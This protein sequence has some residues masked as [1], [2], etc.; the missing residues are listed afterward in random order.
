VESVQLCAA[1]LSCAVVVVF[2]LAVSSKR[3][4][5]EDALDWYMRGCVTAAIV[6]VYQLAN[7]ITH[8][9]YPDAVLYSNPSYVIYR[10][11]KINGLWRLNGPFT[12]ASDMAGAMVVG[13]ALVGW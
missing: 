10:A 2:L 11:Y 4:D 8:I 9:P 7:A 5:L 1:V 12:E 3:K 6:A 13:L